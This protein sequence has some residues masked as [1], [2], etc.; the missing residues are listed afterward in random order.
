MSKF[1]LN[2]LVQISKALVYLKI[3]FYSEKNF[4]GLS[5]QPW[6]VFFSFQPTIF[7]LS[8]WASGSRPANPPSR[9]NRSSSSSRTGAKR[10][11]RRRPTSRRP[12]V[13]PDDLNR[14]ENNGLINPPSILH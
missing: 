12:M 14:K 6:P 13:D 1:L 2:L 10:A 8:H 9:P 7:S 4:S 3:K 5:A 11:R